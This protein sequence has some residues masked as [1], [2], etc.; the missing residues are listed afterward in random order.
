M[1]GKS[2]KETIT[3]LKNVYN[4]YGKDYK[5]S[6]IKIT[7]YSIYGIFTNIVIPLLSAKFIISFTNSMFKQAIYMS[8]VILVVGL[9]ERVKIVLIRKN[10]Q[11]FRRGTVRNIQMSLG[12]EIL[13]LNQE[14]LDSTSSGT[15]IQRLTN[16]TEKMSRI[17]TNGMVITIKFLSCVG[18]FIAVLIIDYHMFL[19]YVV[20][21][22]ILTILNYIKHE[23]VGEKDKE[24]RKEND[25]VAG[26]TGELVRGARDIKML[27]AKESFM[28]NLDEK[29]ML[30]NEKTFEMR[31]IDMNYNFIIGDIEL[32]LELI[33]VI[34]LILLIKNN[35][36]TVAV[37][38]AIYN[39]KKTVLT[40]FMD[41]V[42]EL[43]EECKNFNI[44]CERIFSI[45]NSKDFKK[46]TFGKEEITNIE[47][48]FEFKNVKFGYNEELVLDNLSLKINSGQTYGIVGK[49]GAGKTTIFNLLNKLYDIKSGSILIDGKNINDLSEKS[50]RGNITIISQS[51]YIF[52]MSIR[53]NLKLVKDDVTEEEIESACKL[54]CLD[55]YINRLPDKLDTIIGEGGVNLS[56][57]QRQRLAIARA[58]VQNTKI[59][60]FDEATSALDNDTQSK[61]QKAIDNLKGKYIIIIIAH[62][63]STIVNCDKIFILEKGRISSSGTH[64]ALIK[65][66][67]YYRKLCETELVENNSKR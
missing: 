35:I 47:G 46:E 50:I 60:L 66:N 41:I 17:F 6:L 45:I 28:K 38:I 39:Y 20:A 24:L 53:D 29:I 67:K 31:N 65:N 33:T 4:N 3:N 23:K 55:D 42:S 21:S 64:K 54:A 10:N 32:I 18:S 57:G 26:L 8:V 11:I 12:R 2:M 19:F 30:Q 15:F 22:S 44:S 59:I 56:G 51:P 40:N 61:I 34:L 1:K 5:K 7:L 14:S 63:L 13:D 49:S 25:R 16:D 48:N 36:L 58:L 37:A 62:R 52:N 43:L 9:F 27:Y